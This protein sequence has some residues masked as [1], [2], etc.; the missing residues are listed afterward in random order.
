MFV[1]HRTYSSATTSDVIRYLPLSASYI[2]Q[3][4]QQLNSREHLASPTRTDRFLVKPSVLRPHSKNIESSGYHLSHLH[5]LQQLCEHHIVGEHGQGCIR[6]VREMTRR[7]TSARCC[8]L[9]LGLR[10]K[11]VSNLLISFYLRWTG[12]TQ[13]TQAQNSIR[14]GK[15]LLNE[16]F[17]NET[18]FLPDKPPRT[19]RQILKL[20]SSTQR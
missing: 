20:R 2:V 16:S 17:L 10:C 13:A 11:P 1:V 5:I 4:Q 9:V 12:S 14:S 18:P 8:V 19:Q 3:Q 6:R 15:F 7:K